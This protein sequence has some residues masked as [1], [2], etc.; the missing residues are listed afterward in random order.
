MKLKGKIIHRG[1]KT[2]LCCSVI[3]ISVND[4]RIAAV[5]VDSVSKVVHAIHRAL[6]FSRILPGSLLPLLVPQEQEQ[7]EKAEK[8]CC[9]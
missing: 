7:E 3:N 6:I 5:N 8:E 9:S 1:V 2:F 4:F